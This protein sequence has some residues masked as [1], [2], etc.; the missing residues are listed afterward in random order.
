[1]SVQYPLEMESD[2]ES[3]ICEGECGKSDLRERVSRNDEKVVGVKN[4]GG[5]WNRRQEIDG[6]G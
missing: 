2:G 5:S 1:M 3:G 6:E 4:L